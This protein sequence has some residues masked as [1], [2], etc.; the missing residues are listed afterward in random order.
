ML[1]S[2]PEIL[3]QEKAFELPMENNVIIAGAYRPGELVG[4]Q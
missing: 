3:E 4:A 1:E 2:L